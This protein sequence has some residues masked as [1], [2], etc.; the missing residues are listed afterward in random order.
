MGRGLHRSW[1]GSGKPVGI[2]EAP[3]HFGKVFYSEESRDKSFSAV[4]S[5]RMRYI[6]SLVGVQIDSL[7]MGENEE[8]YTGH[9]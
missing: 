4:R 3:T 9:A 6:F 2:A 1:L 7:P 8:V 5:S